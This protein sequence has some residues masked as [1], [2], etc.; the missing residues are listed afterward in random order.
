[1]MTEPQPPEL[2][3]PPHAPAP[4]AWCTWPIVNTPLGW[5][6]LDKY[7]SLAGWLCP[8]PHMR[9]AEPH[10]ELPGEPPM[11][12]QP[13]PNVSPSDRKSVV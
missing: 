10:T 6:H 13:T 11:P 8:E 4:C 2:D 9:L 5:M 7:R 12:V 3:P 1:M